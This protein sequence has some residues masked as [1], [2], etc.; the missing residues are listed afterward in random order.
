MDI[1]ATEKYLKVWMAN[2]TYRGSASPLHIHSGM[3]DKER[4]ILYYMIQVVTG[5]KDKVEE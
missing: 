3:P 5:I 4:V 2:P 1:L